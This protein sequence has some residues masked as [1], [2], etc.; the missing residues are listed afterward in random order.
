MPAPRIASERRRDANTMEVEYVLED[1]RRAT[2]AVP[3]ERWQQLGH[4]PV[5]PAVAAMLA[6]LDL[7]RKRRADSVP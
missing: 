3:Y 1:G 5:G 4:V 7:Q 6:E 2:V